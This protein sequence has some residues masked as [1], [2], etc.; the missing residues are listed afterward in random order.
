MIL[1]EDSLIPKD[2]AKYHGSVQGE[3]A[4]KC[5]RLPD[6]FNGL[7]A[8][9]RHRCHIQ[10]LEKTEISQLFQVREEDCSIPLA[11]G[12]KRGAQ[13][14]SIQRAEERLEVHRREIC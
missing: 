6:L 12:T 13:E 7:I 9:D 3:E 2:N 1:D 11:G 4:C 8:G 14:A 5:L 10:S